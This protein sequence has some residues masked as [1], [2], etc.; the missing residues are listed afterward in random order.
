M[1]TSELKVPATTY[2]PLDMMFCYRIF[3]T[4]TD[5]LAYSQITFTCRDIVPRSHLLVET[6][7]ISHLLAEADP[8]MTFVVDRPQI[9]S[10]CRDIVHR[11][12]LCVETVAQITTCL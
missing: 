4:N 1:A 6:V 7:S 10:P 9:T 2:F 3:Y 8:Q 5:A 12:H 11:L